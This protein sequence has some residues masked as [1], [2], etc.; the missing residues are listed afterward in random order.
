MIIAKKF[1]TMTLCQ[2]FRIKI[3]S[4]KHNVLE[5]KSV[6]FSCALLSKILASPCRLIKKFSLVLNFTS[7][8]LC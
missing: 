2:F 5:N 3:L 1:T 8:Q 7:L 4:Q 6:A